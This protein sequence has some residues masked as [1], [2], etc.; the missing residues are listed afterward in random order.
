[1]DRTLDPDP[2]LIARFAAD[3]DALVAPG[4]RIGVAVSGG[5]DSLA[6][7]LLASAARP[8]LVEA[9]T[10][11]H[12]LRAESRAEAAMVADICAGL[13]VP[14]AAL[15]VHWPQKPDSNLQ[16]RAR[17]ARYE[18]LSRWARDRNLTAV[19][20]AHHA[21]DQAET[22][23]MRLARGAG[24][25]GLVGA[26][27]RRML[28]PGIA[29]VRPLLGWRRTELAAIVRAAGLT[30]VDDP[31]NRDPRHDRSRFRSLLA[32]ADWADVERMAGSAGW[33][34]E[35]DE[36][37]EWIT[38]GLA[39]SRVVADG[40]ALRIDADGLPRE[41]QRRLLLGA[42]DRFDAARPRGPHLAR[43]LD[44]LLHGQVT[45]LSGL[46]LEPGPPWRIA[47]A[48]PRST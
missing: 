32:T 6:L 23:L 26:R 17:E 27:R 3:L 14:H 22:L 42:F 44:K 19:A 5:P 43:A 45:T 2:G 48:P 11:D 12:G 9:A 38:A 1:M 47:P 29:L 40:A 37:L 8:G 20:T 39:A 34:G 10:V 18:Q 7:L 30:P 24:L 28:E 36:A 41:L 16:A 46:K 31:A 13:A 4:E 15:T 25:P 33:L 21:D 35:A